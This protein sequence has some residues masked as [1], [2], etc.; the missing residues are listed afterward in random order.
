MIPELADLGFAVHWLRTRSKA[1]LLKQWSTAPVLTPAQ[2]RAGWKPGRNVGVRLGEPSRVCGGFLHV[3]DMDV[4]R[5]SADEAWA[6]VLGM[7]PDARDWPRVRSGSGG[8]SRHLYFLAPTAFRSRKLAH[9]DQSYVD[10]EGHKHWFWEVE[11]FGTGKQVVLPP[12]IHPDTGREYQ[13]EVALDLDEVEVAG[14]PCAPVP[15][16]VLEHLTGQRAGADETPT[17]PTGA[18]VDAVR[19]ILDALDLDRWCEDRE[20]WLKVGMALHHEFGGDEEGFDL[21]CEFSEQSGKFDI[22]VQRKTWDAFRPRANGVTLRSLSQASGVPIG[23][24]VDYADFLDDV[25]DEDAGEDTWLEKLNRKHAIAL[26]NGK[27]VVITERPEGVGYGKPSDIH[28]YYQNVQIPKGKGSESVSEAWMR[29]PERRTYSHVAFAPGGCSPKVFNLWRGWAVEPKAGS[30]QL[31]LDHMHEV[32]CAGDADLAE[33]GLDWCAQLIQQPQTKTGTAFVVKGLK[34]AGKD[35]MFR[36]LGRLIHRSHCLIVADP[37]AILGQFNNHLA[38]AVLV[39]GEEAFWSGDKRH[40]GILK[41]LITSDELSIEPK[42][43]DRFQVPFCARFAFTTNED[44]AAPATFDER[45]WFVVEASAHRK[46]DE[47]YFD[48]FKDPALPSAFMRFL[49][50]RKITRNLRDA[51]KTEA[52]SQQVL[53]SL[54]GVEW[55]WSTILDA[56]KLPTFEVDGD[57]WAEGSVTAPKQDLYNHYCR[58]LQTARYKGSATSL[59]NFGA[60]MAAMCPGMSE[61]RIETNA[62]RVR[63]LRLP[64]LDVC[65][66]AFEDKLK[67]KG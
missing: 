31:L 8:D 27:A 9:S 34:G 38:L 50:D 20:G 53:E 11:L 32:I 59:R 45:R 57:E 23:V 61:A 62:G 63:A 49:L 26:I 64:P 10:D 6:S 41:H 33:W 14:W 30:C 48:L 21:W 58:A 46:G 3:L 42:G 55:W 37:K 54:M 24:P 12:S 5:G 51:P 15:A 47:A 28:A 29:H 65:V 13:W 2:V 18:T 67:G 43:V 66:K 44:W 60:K 19:A 56:E 22:E 25:D 40:E 16:S 1:P 4:R 35:T 7:F 17:P 39:H 52:L 36:A